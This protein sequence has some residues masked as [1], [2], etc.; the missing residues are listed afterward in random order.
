MS[1]HEAN[2][3]NQR[4]P[5]KLLGLEVVLRCKPVFIVNADHGLVEVGK[6]IVRFSSIVE[7]DWARLITPSCTFRK[8]KFTLKFIAHVVHSY[9]S[10]FES[11]QSLVCVRRV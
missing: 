9:C 6:L 2:G 1:L 5:D 3:A 10:K 7:Q 4:S 11:G 8:P